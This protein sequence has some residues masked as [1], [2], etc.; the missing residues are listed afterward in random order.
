[1]TT[2]NLL[3]EILMMLRSF[4]DDRE[5]LEKLHQY[6]LNELYTQEG[7]ATEEIIIPERY[8]SLVKDTADSLSAGM[9]SYINPATLEKIDIPQSVVDT[10][11]L[12][13]EDADDEV[14]EDDPFMKT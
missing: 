5:Q 2:N 3:D 7:A 13:E 6:M 4:K 10:I 9:V 1:M 11:I 8:A 14:E 12:D